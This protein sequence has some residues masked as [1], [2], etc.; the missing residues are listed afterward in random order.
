MKKQFVF[1][2]VAL[3]PLLASAETVKIKDIYYNLIAETN[4]AEVTSG[5][6][7]YSGNITIPS[8]I[9]YED[10]EYSV[11]SIGSKAFYECSSLSTVTISENSKLAIIG[12]DAFFNCSSLTSITI[13]ES[14]TS[15]GSHAFYRCISLTSITIPE[16]SKLTSIGSRAFDSCISLTSISIPESVTSIGSSAFDSCRSLT[17]ISIPESV[18]SIGD[19]AFSYCSSLTSITIPE[20]SK[21]TSI[22]SKAFY[23]CSSLTSITI[24]ESVTSIDN[25]AFNYCSSLASI[26]CYAEIPPKCGI[27]V[28]TGV[29]R[30]IPLCVPRA[31]VG[32]YETAEEWKTFTNIIGIDTGIENIAGD[33]RIHTLIYDINGVVMDCDFNELPK[34]VYIQNGKKFVVK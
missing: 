25:F 8:T 4:E 33:I 32:E 30:T 28:F 3:L 5:S 13:P 17:S 24:P 15:I 27:S 9:T 12:I 26:T 11:T 22:R 31:A 19:E 21:L 7:K 34:G 20:N 14:V 6:P 18:T 16:N 29:D 2:L 23:N 10:V 1:I